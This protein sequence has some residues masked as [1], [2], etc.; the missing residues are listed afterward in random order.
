[1]WY[2][3]GC[4]VKAE[5]KFSRRVRRLRND[6]EKAVLIKRRQLW[7]KDRRTHI[8]LEEELKLQK[9]H[10]ILCPEGERNYIRIYHLCM[11]VDGNP[12]QHM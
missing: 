6:S 12:R 11:C 3:A 2:D 10:G 7:T 4:F 9:F 1:M 5:F 8:I